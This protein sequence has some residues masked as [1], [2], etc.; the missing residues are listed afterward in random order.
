VI[1]GVEKSDILTESRWSQDLLVSN[2]RKAV[3]LRVTGGDQFH[4]AD[5]LELKI[6]STVPGVVIVTHN[7]RELGQVPTGSGKLTVP[8]KQLG[9]GPVTLQAHTAGSPGV[10]S[11]P[12]KIE[13]R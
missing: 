5:Q 6:D 9:K 8:A 4:S 11:R 12:V 1:A 3:E 13:V 2:A 7:G 10:R